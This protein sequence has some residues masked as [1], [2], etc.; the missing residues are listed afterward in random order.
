MDAPNHNISNWQLF[1]FIW[2]FLKL[3]KWTFF[4][5]LILDSLA[6]PFDALLWPYILREVVDLF[7]QFDATRAEALSY[8]YKPM[9]LALM[10]VLFVETASRTMGFLLAK[11]I[12][13][14]QSAIRLKMFDHIQHHTPRY[15]ND[16]FAG[17][18]SA[19][20]NDMT[21]HI[22]SILDQLFWPIIPALSAT[23]LGA[24]MLWSVHPLFTFILIIWMSVHISLCVL[25]CKTC[26]A[27]EQIHANARSSLL[28]R[29]VDSLT[30]NY[31]VNLFYRFMEEK[32]ALFPFQDKEENSNICAKCVVEKMRCYLSLIYFS[33]VILGIFGSLIYLWMHYKISTGEVIQVFTTMWSL[34][35]ILWSVGSALPV[36]FQSVGIAKQAYTLM[37]DPED[38]GDLPEAAPLKVT[39]GE[40]VFENVSFHYGKKKMFENKHVKIEAG[41]KVGLVGFTG[42]GKS[43]FINLILRFYPVKSGMILIDGQNIAEVCLRSIRQQIA[44]I[45]QDPMLFHRTLWENIRFGNLNATEDEIKNAARLAHCEEFIHHIPNGYQAKVGERGTKLSGGERQRIAIA[46]AFLKN[47]PILILD[48][49]TSA[50]DSLTEALIQDSLA[51]IMEGKTT[52]VIAHRLSTLS[53]MDRILV[54]EK[55]KIVEEGSHTALIK[56]GGL[57][58]KMWKTQSGN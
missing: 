3:Q 16:R 1:R 58:A 12:P 29:I 36:V 21:Y 13:K 2:P 42:A 50:L 39:K 6:W 49:A 56:Q 25:F 35:M 4:F 9:V 47:A 17:S 7:T 55:G 27:H 34:S 14:M 31:S 43:T 41:E 46:R 11:A 10:L 38:L 28:G 30:N 20:I 32:Q 15:F 57:Y 40:I 48:E 53:K 54:F 52:L 37:L 33:A 24:L 18:L 23:I 51:K 8:V 44:L 19:R 5:I 45:P 26:D 22:E